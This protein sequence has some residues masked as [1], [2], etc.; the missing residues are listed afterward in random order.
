MQ[1][2]AQL[3]NKS[4]YKLNEE[5]EEGKFI[6]E[7]DIEILKKYI[8]ANLVGVNSNR[9]W[10]QQYNYLNKLYIV[11]RWRK[12]NN[13]LPAARKGEMICKNEI[14]NFLEDK[15]HKQCCGVV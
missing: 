13:L 15:K 5:F 1:A 4:G 11:I 3:E 12:E 6:Y 7:R 8:C 14:I 2:S 9:Y 10:H